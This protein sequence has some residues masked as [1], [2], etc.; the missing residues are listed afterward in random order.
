MGTPSFLPPPI[1]IDSLINTPNPSPLIMKDN[2]T[3]DTRTMASVL[4]TLRLLS[5]I[6]DDLEHL[7]SAINTYFMRVSSVEQQNSFYKDNSSLLLNDSEF[8]VF[9]KSCKEILHNKLSF[10]SY[11]LSKNK[12]RAFLTSIEHINKLLETSLLLDCSTKEK[13]LSNSYEAMIK[14]KIENKVIEEFNKAGRSL[15]QEEKIRLVDAEYKRIVP[16]LSEELSKPMFSQGGSSSSN[17]DLRKVTHLSLGLS[18][19]CLDTQNTGNY[20]QNPSNQAKMRKEDSLLVKNINWKEIQKVVQTVSQKSSETGKMQRKLNCVSVNSSNSN[21]SIEENDIEII[22]DD[23]VVVDEVK[24]DDIVCL[25]DL[26]FNDL[27]QLCTNIKTLDNNTQGNL[28]EY[29]KKLEKTNPLKVQ[30]LQKCINM[31]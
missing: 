28:I 10:V 8:L 6:E 25:D 20:N 1:N 30:E 9:L 19:K 31:R 18:K 26:N 29:M 16:E 27:V 12:E 23:V 24:Q 21:M 11:G 13:N 15:N 4:Q 7:G 2:E 14:S 3:A 17:V 5:A 22:D